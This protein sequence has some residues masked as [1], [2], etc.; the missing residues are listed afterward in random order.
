MSLLAVE[1]KQR[2]KRVA[3]HVG[4]LNFANR[5]EYAYGNRITP[6]TLDFYR[7]FIPPCSL[8]FD[9]GAH[10]G[11]KTR[12]FRQ[13]GAAVIAV[14]PLADCCATLQRKFGNDD[15][16]ILFA[17]ACGEV[18]RTATLHRSSL[19][20]Q[21]S[22]LS[23]D[24]AGN[25]GSD[26]EWE[27]CDRIEVTTLDRLIEQHGLPAFCKIDTEGYELDVLKGL[28]VA[29]P[30]LS[31]EFHAND[32]GRTGKCVQRLVALGYQ[33]F[34]YICEPTEEFIAADW[35]S[36]AALLARLGENDLDASGNVFAR[37]D[38]NNCN[39]RR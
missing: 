24:F 18:E 36:P 21:N 35:L 1:T 16:V 11:G 22:T 8:C 19:N 3:R 12:L 15:R 28:S 2:I 9:I 29:I 26:V 14:E 6:A 17:G 39:Q 23:D 4:L 10:Y 27:D 33:R 20:P 5:I 13:L 38:V 32:L 34:N 37:A 25:L 30:A 31:F 7:A